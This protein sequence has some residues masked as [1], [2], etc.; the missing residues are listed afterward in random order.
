MS[1]ER[2]IAGLRARESAVSRPKVEIEFTHERIEGDCEEAEQEI[3]RLRGA[4]SES[5]ARVSALTAALERGAEERARYREA[6]A[7]LVT[8]ADRVL[9]TESNSDLRLNVVTK[10]DLAVIEARNVL[11]AADRQ[12]DG[13]G[14][15]MPDMTDLSIKNEEPISP[16][17]GAQIEAL[18][19]RLESLRLT[20][21]EDEVAYWLSDGAMQHD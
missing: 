19:A 20:T 10:L 13:E 11:A 9:D 3:A 7:N 1:D 17:D 15:G 4:L 16:E 6:L 8:A 14:R 5:E 18:K 21:H 12:P 2:Q